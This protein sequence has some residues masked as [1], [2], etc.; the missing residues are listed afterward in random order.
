M[1]RRWSRIG[2]FKHYVSKKVNR[3]AITVGDKFHRLTVVEIRLK[4]G[5]GNVHEVVCRCECNALVTTSPQSLRKG[6]VT[7]CPADA[8]LEKKYAKEIAAAKALER[9]TSPH[10]DPSELPSR[11]RWEYVP[12][13]EPSEE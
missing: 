3:P 10:V 6:Y 4:K 7:A 11:S 13:S 8:V 9:L 2:Q 1:P 5:F 12:P